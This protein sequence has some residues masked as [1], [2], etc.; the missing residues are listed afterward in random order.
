MLDRRQEGL[1]I[2]LSLRLLGVVR[3]TGLLT[4]M[5]DPEW[6]AWSAVPLPV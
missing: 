1:F 2:L 3:M 6:I 4:F 5:I